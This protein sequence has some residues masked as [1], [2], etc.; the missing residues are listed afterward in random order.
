MKLFDKTINLKNIRVPFCNVAA[1]FDHIV[2]FPTALSTA[3][4]IGTSPEDQVT[5]K[6]NGGHVRGVVNPLLYP[7]LEG[8]IRQYSGLKNRPV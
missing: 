8:F 7:L 3:Y 5:I 6:I 2:E 1:L 4:L